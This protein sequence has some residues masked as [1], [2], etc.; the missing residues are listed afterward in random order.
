MSALAQP[1]GGERAGIKAQVVAARTSFYWAMRFLPKP[2]RE[3]MFAIYAFCRAVDDIVD[4]DD[5][6]AVKLAALAEW[7]R[8][9]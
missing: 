2:R 6:P 3:A 9:V 5:A 8:T 1:A 4:S 7:R